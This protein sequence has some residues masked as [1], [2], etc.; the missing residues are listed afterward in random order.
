MLLNLGIIL[1]K[2]VFIIVIN[3]VNVFAQY[4]YFFGTFVAMKKLLYFFALTF[5]IYSCS[6]ESPKKDDIVESGLM[7]G[8]WLL[9]FYLAENTIAPSFFNLSNN[10]DSYSVEFINAQETISTKNVVVENKKITI[11]DP[12][13]NSWFEG[14][15]VDQ[16]T[17]KGFWYKND[18]TYSIPF[19]AH[20]GNENRFKNNVSV[21]SKNDVSG[22]WEVDFSRGNPEDFYKAI[23]QFEQ[24]E[25]VLTGTFMTETGDYRFLEGNV[26]GDSLFLSCFDGAHLFLFKAEFKNDSLIG[27]FWSGTHWQEPWIAGRNDSF[28]LTNPDSLT[29]LKEGYDKLA[30]TFPNLNGESVSLSDEKYKNK[31]VI[32]N[33]MAPWCPNCKDETSYLSNLY[34]AN[35]NKGLEIIALSFDKSDDFETSK[36]NIEKIKNHFGV[37]YDFLIAGQASKIEAA[38]ALPM[39][40]HIMSYPTSIFIDKQGNIRKIRTGFYGPGTGD[41]YTRYTEQIDSFIEK[42]LAE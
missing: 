23:G 36:K 27:T 35:H 34:K 11:S 41:Y 17:I 13:F 21:E 33:I 14:E 4:L 28:E 30:F 15:I 12:I 25:D 42:L 26:Y 9:N 8:K 6:S 37:D 19:E 22:K 29:F 38:Q 40:N 3:L 10:G 31:V 39:L 20:F 18:K 7:N 16:K 1:L 2:R 5:L 32:V 24:K